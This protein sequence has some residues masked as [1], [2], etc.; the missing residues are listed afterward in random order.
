MVKRPSDLTLTAD[1]KTL[2]VADKFGDVYALPLIPSADDSLGEDS[3]A[4]LQE[5]IRLARKGA[6]NLTVHTQRNLRS[7]EEQARQRAEK[8]KQ[9]QEQKEA[10][11]T[12]K[13]DLLLGHVSMLTSI[14]VASADGKPYI[15]TAD[16]DEHIRVSRGILSMAHVI[17]N[18]CLGHR[19]FVSAMCL[20]EPDRLVSGGGDNDLY[21]WDWKAGVLKSKVPLLRHAKE[22]ANVTGDKI[23][24]TGLYPCNVPGGAGLIMAICER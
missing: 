22:Q 7:L 13:Q 6:N 14:A 5:S 21:V 2:L 1:E 4:A 8:A 9:Q 18:F 12:F 23:A 11:P 24:V 10:G 3:A 17:E 19:A 15:L 16:R 20:P